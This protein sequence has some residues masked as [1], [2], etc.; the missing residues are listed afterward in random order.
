VFIFAYVLLTDCCFLLQ[1][2]I[3]IR[4]TLWNPPL[5]MMMMMMCN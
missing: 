2:L 3:R 5:M 4:Q 1:Q